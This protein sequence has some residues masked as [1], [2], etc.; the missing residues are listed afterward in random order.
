M[1]LGCALT[2]AALVGASRSIRSG[3]RERTNKL[4][5]ARVY[6]QGFTILALVA[7]SMY[8]K[9]D[10]QKRKEFDQAVQDRIAREKR[11]AWVKELEARDE[12]QKELRALKEARRNGAKPIPAMANKPAANSI[13]NSKRAGGKEDPAEMQLATASSVSEKGG[14][15]GIL[16]TVQGWVWGSKK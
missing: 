6:A 13:L 3:D 15:K 12:E 16:G 14:D 4:F 5:R 2:V 7:G 9:T 8:W 1:P 10:R 11:D